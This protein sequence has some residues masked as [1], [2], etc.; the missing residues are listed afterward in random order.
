MGSKTS[1]LE[2]CQPEGT[3]YSA[4]EKC[5]AFGGTGEDTIQ[6]GSN[7]WVIPCH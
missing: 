6:Y 3:M 2:A 1:A 5:H 7:T 4:M